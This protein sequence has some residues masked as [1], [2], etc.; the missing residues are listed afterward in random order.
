MK[1]E[2]GGGGGGGGEGEEGGAAER[3]TPLK[4]S[5]HD[6]IE[7]HIVGPHRE[8]RGFKPTRPHGSCQTFG[9]MEE[10]CLLLCHFYLPE[11]RTR[12]TLLPE[13]ALP[14]GT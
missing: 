12:P 13:A 6:M 11:K 1:K 2:G 9:E 4:T 5:Q 10:S 14:P 3:P 8:P 7:R